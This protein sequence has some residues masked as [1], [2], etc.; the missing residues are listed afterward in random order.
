MESQRYPELPH[1][2]PELDDI[3]PAFHNQTNPCF[4]CAEEP[5]RRS[6]EILAAPGP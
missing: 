6:G 5:G 3:E 1:E 4:D 2:F